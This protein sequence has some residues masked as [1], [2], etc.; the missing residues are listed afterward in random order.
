MQNAFI[1][2]FLVSIACG[3]VGS[4]AVINKMS[5][6]SGGVAH[7][8]FGGIGIAI[9]LGISPILGASVFCLA[10]SLLIG[11]LT[12]KNRERF[13]T[14]IGV[15]WA[16]G[17][18]LGILF[19]DLTPGYK[20]DLMSYL[21]GSILAIDEKVL[22]FIGVCDLLFIALIALFYRQFCA[23]SFDMEFAKLRDVKTELFY[24]LLVAMISFCVVSTIQI[25]GL[26]LV[27]ALMSIPTFIAEKFAARLG[28]MMLISALLSTLFCAIGLIFSYYFNVSSGAGI[29]LAASVGFFISL[30]IKKS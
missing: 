18:A 17:M 27:V 12:L 4:L 20:G 25:V 22:L 13:D 30:L 24:Y 2:A 14:I 29:I 16:F 28:S 8:A 15:L 5:F 7:A 9:F 19:I 3:I 23:I 26:I 21:F 6:I 1:G 11:F 10:I